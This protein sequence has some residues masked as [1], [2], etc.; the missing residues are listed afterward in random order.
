MIK[1]RNLEGRNERYD[2]C[3]LCSQKFFIK[4]LYDEFRVSEVE[5]DALIL[6]LQDQ[7]KE[8]KKEFARVRSERHNKIRE[9]YWTI[10]IIHD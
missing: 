9:V 4:Q 6:K 8:R 5:K 7:L 1:K 2:I 3:E 10:I